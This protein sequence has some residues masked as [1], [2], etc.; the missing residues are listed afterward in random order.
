MMFCGRNQQQGNNANFSEIKINDIIATSE[1]VANVNLI[2]VWCVRSE[3]CVCVSCGKM[4]CCL[5]LAR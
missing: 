5:T 4:N 1:G 3:M 2:D